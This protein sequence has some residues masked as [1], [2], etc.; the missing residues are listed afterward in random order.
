MAEIRLPRIA[1]GAWA[2][3]NVGTFGGGIDAE[4]TE[5]EELADTL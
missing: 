1:L 3:G 4:V 5:L 2:W